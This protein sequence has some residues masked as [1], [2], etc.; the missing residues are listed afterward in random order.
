[1]MSRAAILAF[2]ATMGAVT[3]S[4][5]GCTSVNSSGLEQYAPILKPPAGEVTGLRAQ[6]FGVST[7]LV[8]DG[9]TS[10]MVDG[11]FSR[12][13]LAAL[14]LLGR[15][16]DEDR[17]NAALVRG[18]VCAVDVLLVA[19]SHFDH[20]MDAP[21]VARKTGAKLVGSESTL[22][23]ARG[24]KFENVRSIEDGV[25]LQRG[26]FEIRFFKSPHGRPWFDFMDVRGSIKDR[27]PV[28]ARMG[29]YKSDVNYTFLLR[30]PAGN[31][32]VVP[33]ANIPLGLGEEK[34]DV[35]F[36]GVGNLSVRPKKFNEH[37]F[38]E[39]YW[40]EAVIKT[41]AKLVIPVH[42]DNLSGSLDQ[43]L[44]LPPAGLDDVMYS[45]AE[46]RKLADRDNVR[47]GI[48]PLFEPVPLP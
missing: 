29:D 5:P 19:H 37:E 46:L 1:M 15:K 24:E 16:P 41:R 14:A 12:P 10:I 42:W 2:L 48:M 27:L 6:F 23:I 30:H 22:T 39:S 28:P 40:T 43:P 20:A 36:L 34:A 21:T 33:S 18:R 7:I 47:L 8:S 17:I 31:I 32:L 35:V 26:A 25:S 9:K 13:G 11:Y 38:I 3:A 44:E 45:M 4:V